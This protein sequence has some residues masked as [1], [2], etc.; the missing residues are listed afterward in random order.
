MCNTV[1]YI[2]WTDPLVEFLANFTQESKLKALSSLNTYAVGL[3]INFDWTGGHIPP[4]DTL[5]TCLQGA[6]L[7]YIPGGPRNLSNPVIAF[8]TWEY[9]TNMG[10]VYM[11]NKTLPQPTKLGS[12][13]GAYYTLAAGDFTLIPTSRYEYSVKG[14][15]TQSQEIHENKRIC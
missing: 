6:K 13:P 2:I 5:E 15:F 4:Q 8:N 7:I 12:L 14:L 1:T 11:F 3:R 10:E 9:L